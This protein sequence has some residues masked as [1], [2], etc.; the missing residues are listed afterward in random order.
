MS[1]IKEVTTVRKDSAENDAFG[2]L[3]TSSDGNRLD[4]EFIVDSVNGVVPTSN[5]DL[6]IKL[7]NLRD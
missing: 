4:C 1:Y 5:E 3:R 7:S 2:R 6:M